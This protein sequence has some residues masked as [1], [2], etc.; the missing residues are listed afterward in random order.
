[1]GKAEAPSACTSLRS[2]IWHMGPWCE[3]EDTSNPGA[4]ILLKLSSVSSQKIAGRAKARRPSGTPKADY[5]P[6]P[7]FYC[8][9]TLQCP[10]YSRG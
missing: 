9:I 3:A 8:I 1:M 5:H 6:G 4:S 2:L 7:D 10:M